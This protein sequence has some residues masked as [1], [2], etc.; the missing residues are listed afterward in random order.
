MRL[1]QGI[2]DGHQK[3]FSYQDAGPLH[4]PEEPSL[5]KADLRGPPDAH[6]L[7]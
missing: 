2:A 5:G 4:P 1:Y 7:E 6:S 3:A